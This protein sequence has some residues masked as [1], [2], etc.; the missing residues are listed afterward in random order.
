MSR[1]LQNHSITWNTF[2][3][4]LS[5]S[6]FYFRCRYENNCDI[7]WRDRNINTLN[8]N[9]SLHMFDICHC[10][11]MFDICRT[12]RCGHWYTL[13]TTLKKVG[14]IV[15]HR[16]GLSVFCFDCSLLFVRASCWHTKGGMCYPGC[17]QWPGTS[18][19]QLLSTERV[20][21]SA[22]GWMDGD[23]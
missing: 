1:F 14:T 2:D 11:Y 18:Q 4:V 22:A 13:V 5:V 19:R 21:V 7:C 23:V 10:I 8:R 20:H 9:M 17:G 12:V 16:V 15:S 3:L 6:I